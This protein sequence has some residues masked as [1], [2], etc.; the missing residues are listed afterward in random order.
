MTKQPTIQRCKH[1]PENPYFQVT[2]DLFRDNSISIGAR[3]LMGYFLSLKDGWQIHHNHL[4]KAI[5]TTRHQIDKYL[6]EL[7]E[8]GYC[9]RERPS[10]KGKFGSYIYEI[11]ESK[12]FAQEKPVLKSSTGLENEIPRE[13]MPPQEVLNQCRNSTV[14]NRHIRT[15]KTKGE[16]YSS[17]NTSTT[18]KPPPDL[19]REE[20]SFSSSKDKDSK[21]TPSSATPNSFKSQDEMMDWVD[22]YN[23]EQGCFIQAKTLLRWYKTYEVGEVFNAM[24]H[25]T[26]MKN[27][28]PIAKPEA[29]IEKSLKERYWS[30]D[31][32]R[33]VERKN[34]S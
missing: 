6:K 33:Q 25:F 1:D 18:T 20:P 11:S 14:E 21:A 34:V 19:N 2:R 8:A 31:F 9:K 22:K 23:Q 30:V 26:K 12:R 15:N 16:T 7:I 27:K 4:Q 13:E 17:K 29:Y 28:K 10:I 24:V 32:K 3:G 5:N